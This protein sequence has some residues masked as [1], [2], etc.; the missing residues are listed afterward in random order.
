MPNTM[1]RGAWLAGACALAMLASAQLPAR[2]QAQAPQTLVI[3]GGT[4]IDGTGAPPIENAVIVIEG[5]RFKSIG[6]SGE[7]VIPPG[8][9]VVDVTGK[10]ILPGFLDG[11]CHWEDFYG[12]LYLHL[13]ITTC[14]YIEVFQDGPWALAQRD[15]TNQG[16]IRGP[17][18]WVSGRAL[19]S[20]R[21]ETDAP[22]SRESRGNIVIRTPEEARAAVQLKKQR[23]YDLLK[24]NE[25]L[26]N[27]LIQVV[28]DEAHRL[29]L[30]V[31]AH[32]WDAIG[33][34]EAG[35]DGIEHI[36][37][38]GY[39]SIA[40][41]DARRKVAADRLA[42]KID[43]EEVGALYETE[44]FDEVINAMVTHHV[45]WTPTIAKWL[46][47]LSPSAARFRARENEILDDPQAGFPDTL[48]TITDSA[49]DKL[50]VKYKP[51]Q[52]ARA[53]LGY[54]KAN[55]FI[56]RF[57]QA[58]GL[59]KEGSDPPRGMAGL[60][61]H[62][63]MTMDVEAGIS[64]M[65]AI[66]AGTL[67]VAKTFKKDKDYGSVEPGK[68]ADLA[69]IEGDPLKDIWMTQNVKM[70]VMDGKFVD[71][72]F[73]NYKN[74][75]PSFY[76]YQTLPREITISPLMVTQGTGPT[77]LIVKG[78]G[79]WPFH[80]VMLN[81]KPLETRLAARNQLEAIIP[82]EA[83][84]DAGDYLVTVKSRGEPLP[85]SN[86]AHLVVRFKQ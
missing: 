31:T 81:G 17:R 67:N 21:T 63:A 10:T 75:I 11:H 8:A 85:E 51:E 50:L 20:D 19:G 43:A 48:R 80:Q 24:I 52:L 39:S 4:L 44:H 86:P 61:M 38:V 57:V 45:A 15:G 60:L 26:G 16:K 79:M 64:P 68:I 22:D 41:L 84:A 71:I 53:R 36:W 35:V 1:F 78:R 3:Q 74:P 46:R 37:S 55:E 47:P 72:G 62:E 23:G 6:R 13:G 73:H 70:L 69:I 27:D 2:A 58:G 83:I 14:A 5:D 77:R 65:Q 82:P 25:F 28:T 76:A 29:G 54:D 33:S 30:A 49:Y 59:L 18:L 32:S 42:G 66:Q 12:E 34:S 9:Q 7:V 56:R 40:D